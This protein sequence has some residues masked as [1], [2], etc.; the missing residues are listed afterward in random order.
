MAFTS[1]S[2]SLW[3]PQVS[4]H[5]ESC[6]CKGL[7]IFGT[8]LHNISH[9]VSDKAVHG[10]ENILQ[11]CLLV[12]PG[13]NC[14]RTAW[15]LS[16]SSMPWGWYCNTLSIW[17]ILWQLHG[18]LFYSWVHASINVLCMQFENWQ[19]HVSMVEHSNVALCSGVF[20]SHTRYHARTT[21]TTLAAKR[22]NRNLLRPPS[23]C[24]V[25]QMA[26][27]SAC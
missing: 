17:K 4:L 24:T 25:I 14:L 9:A 22:C 3:H 27:S 13:G 5:A 2:P 8:L 16:L 1:F 12:E 19:C 7:R 6:K 26:S 15:M 20:P 11:L 21:F 23:K 10:M 18:S